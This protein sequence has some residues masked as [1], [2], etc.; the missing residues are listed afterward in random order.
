MAVRPVAEAIRCSRF[1]PL[2][3]IGFCAVGF[4]PRHHAAVAA[5]ERSAIVHRPQPPF[6]LSGTIQILQF[7]NLFAHFATG[8]LLLALLLLHRSQS[9]VMAGACLDRWA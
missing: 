1:V 9:N 3:R 8:Q 2:P 7:S 4:V 6:S 5:I